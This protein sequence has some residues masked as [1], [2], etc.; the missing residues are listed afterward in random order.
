MNANILTLRVWVRREFLT[1]GKEPGLEEGYAFAVMSVRGRALQFHVL[2]K[3]GAHFRGLPIHALLTYPAERAASGD[4]SLSDL[5]LWDCFSSRPVVTVFDL[6]RDHEC[7]AWLRDGS[8]LRGSYLFT[9]DWLPDSEE[10]PGWVNQPDQNKCG[11]V[12]ELE[13]GQLAC[14]PTNRIAFLD[15]YFIGNDPEPEKAGYVTNEAVWQAETCARWDV[16]KE[17]AMFYGA[18]AQVE[19]GV[20]PGLGEG[21]TPQAPGELNERLDREARAGENYILR[22]VGKLND[23]IAAGEPRIDVE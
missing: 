22:R 6:L 5:Q 18:G 8:C 3:S 13:N 15:G 9:V 19:T 23:L 10:A 12:L 16:S 1:N 21:V 17:E 20:A 2:L 4:K 14:L 11:H 7:K